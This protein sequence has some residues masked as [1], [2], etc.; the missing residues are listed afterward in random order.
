MGG[1][2]GGVGDAGIATSDAEAAPAAE[3]AAAP[4]T[5]GNVVG[6]VATTPAGAAV[7]AVVF[8]EDGPVDPPAKRAPVIDNHMMNFVPFVQVVQAGGRVIFQNSDPFPHNVFSPDNGGFN[9]GVIPQHASSSRV[10]KTPGAFSLLCNLHPGMLGYVVATPNGHFA[11]TN[12]T[13]RY[14]IKDVAPGTYHVTAW[15][16][17]QKPITQSVTITGGDVTL[18]FELHR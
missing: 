13:G 1:T 12:A 2:P 3:P 11:R 18:D 5:N 14:T 8:F 4:A 15:A 16:P 17:R 7:N 10:F 9:I 6:H